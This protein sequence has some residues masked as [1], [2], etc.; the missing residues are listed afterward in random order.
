[1]MMR[2]MLI[3]SHVHIPIKRSRRLQ[4]PRRRILKPL[5]DKIFRER[6]TKAQV[7]NNVGDIGHVRGQVVTFGLGL[8]VKVSGSAI[9]EEE[10]GELAA[11]VFFVGPGVGDFVAAGG[12]GVGVGFVC[13]GADGAFCG[14]IQR[15]SRLDTITLLLPLMLLLHG[16]NKMRQLHHSTM[17][18]IIPLLP[19]I[20]KELQSRIRSNLMIQTQLVMVHAV[21]FANEDWELD[22]HGRRVFLVA[23]FANFV[24]FHVVV[25]AGFGHF[26][27]DLGECFPGG[28]QVTTM[29]APIGEEID[30]DVGVLL[31]R[32]L[33]RCCIEGNGI[34]A[35]LVEFFNR[36]FDGTVE[37]LDIVLL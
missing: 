21:H 29:G 4:K 15:I 6:L 33:E 26:V 11:G 10:A 32:H 36:L 19:P 9:D 23:E 1:M 5:L 27:H 20:H 35:I 13:V 8:N 34:L 30:E 18:P 17:S 3:T 16:L 22:R 12:E 7:I 25:D 14:N 24:F 28:C 37:E 2:L 31:E